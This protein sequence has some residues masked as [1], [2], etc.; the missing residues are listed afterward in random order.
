MTRCLKITVFILLWAVIPGGFVFASDFTVNALKLTGS[1]WGYQTASFTLDYAGEEYKQVVVLSEVTFRGGALQPLRRA[2]RAYLIEPQSSTPVELAVIVPGNYGQGQIRIGLY[3]VVDTLDQLYDSQRFFVKEIPFDFKRPPALQK[4]ITDDI[5]LPAFVGNT[6]IFDNDFNRIMLALLHRGKR[7]AEIAELCGTDV[8]FVKDQ[9]TRLYREGLIGVHGTSFAPRIMVI[10]R[11]L[12][13]KLG[14][15]IKLMAEKMYTVIK[16]NLPILD[17]TVQAMVAGGELTR[18]PNDALDGGAVLYHK[19]PLVMVLFLWDIL[20]RDFV[21]DGKPFNIFAG[22]EPCNAE[23]GEYM[24]I[25]TAGDEYRGRSF[26]YHIDEAGSERI[27]SG[28][29]DFKIYCQADYRARARNRMPI[30]WNFSR[31]NPDLVFMYNP[32]RIRI[33]LSFL[34]AGTTEYVDN[35]RR[36]VDSAYE[37][38]GE[39]GRV[40]GL[41]YWCW[42]LLVTYLMD[43]L[44]Q[45]GELEPEGEGLYTFQRVEY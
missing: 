11:P 13:E 28:L 33:P 12:T 9:L 19:Y 43:H 39:P 17:S 24:Y 8:E 25:L 36:A 21:N 1:D 44:E 2:K 29:G 26:Y 22:S 31:E 42:S 32:D 5:I 18:D 34:M 23:M 30:N 10:D 4:E 40:K 3:D 7:D 15:A 35:L 20:G 45:G 6:D 16:G 27:Y 41:R 37:P 14:P 38:D